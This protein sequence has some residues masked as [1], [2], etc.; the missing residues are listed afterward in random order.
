MVTILQYH[1]FEL[2]NR[3]RQ[4][5]ESENNKTTKREST[6][7]SELAWKNFD[8]NGPLRT[9]RAHF[10]IGST[11]KKSTASTRMQNE[12]DST[13]QLKKVSTVYFSAPSSHFLR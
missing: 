13:F 12:L 10:K 9:N 1:Y 2:K 6:W 8:Q 4:Y 11:H 7:T 5:R 3:D